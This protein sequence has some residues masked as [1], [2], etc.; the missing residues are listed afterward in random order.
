MAVE[1]PPQVAADPFMSAKWDELTAG[2]GFEQSDAPALALLVQWH[3]VVEQC[4]KDIA[5][6]DGVR[7]V[8]ENKLG[9]VRAL[10][11]YAVMKQASAEIRQLDRQLGIADGRGGAQD[12]KAKVTPLEVIRSNYKGRLAAPDVPAGTGA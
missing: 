2:R 12:G 9:D 3:L 4:M 11:H 7:V 6:G 10:P 5:T 1:K 8:Y